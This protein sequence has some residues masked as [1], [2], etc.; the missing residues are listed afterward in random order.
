MVYKASFYAVQE[1]EAWLYPSISRSSR[2]LLFGANA[3]ETLR[4]ATK[5]LLQ[6]FQKYVSFYSV[7]KDRCWKL[8]NC[9][10]RGNIVSVGEVLIA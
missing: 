8:K 7:A 1:M 3:R 10:M 4:H 2:L 6:G 5:S 9:R